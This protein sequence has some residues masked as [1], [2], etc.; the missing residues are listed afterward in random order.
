MFKVCSHGIGVSQR[1]PVPSAPR[2]SRKKIRGGDVTLSVCVC[3][4]I[5]GIGA[6]PSFGIPVLTVP[7][8]HSGEV[9]SVYIII[10]EA[11]QS[12]L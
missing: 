8:W 7:R 1:K 3:T 11:V 5:S 4:H 9:T 12:V 6:V 10:D 2:L